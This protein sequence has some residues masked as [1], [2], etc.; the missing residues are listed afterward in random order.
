MGMSIIFLT[1]IVVTLCWTKRAHA[2]TDPYLWLEEIDSE[3]ALDWA[4]SHN[5]TTLDVLQK[6]ADF[7]AIYDKNL[8]IYNSDQ[9]IPAPSIRGDYIYNFWK[10]E[11]NERG[12]WRRTPLEEYRKSDPTWETLLSIDELS[13][14]ESVKWVYKGVSHFYPDFKRCMVSLSRGGGDAVEIREFD[15][16]TKQFVKDGFFVPHAKGSVSWKDINTLHV[17]TDFGA[18]TTTQS[19][20]P[21]LTKVW[22]RGTPLR[23]AETLFEGE[24]DDVSV[25]SDVTYTPERQYTLIR[26]SITFYKGHYHVIENDTQIK[27]DIPEDAQLNGFFKNQMLIRLRSDW[28]VA[29]KPY[30]QGSLIGIDYDRFLNGDR[31]F[32]VIV[33]PDER[34]SISSV[35]S[36]KNLLLVN[37]LTNVRSR[38]DQYRFEENTWHKEKVN[39]PDLGTISIGSTDEFSDRY[40]FY[41][42][43]F[44]VPSTLYLASEEGPIEKLKS[45]PEFFDSSKFE[46]QQFEATSK[47]GT[48]IPYFLVSNTN[49]EHTGKNPTLLSGYGGFEISRQPDYASTVGHAWL[50]RG[51]VYALANIR[52]GGEFGPQWHQAALQKNRQRAYDDFIAVAEDLIDRNITSPQHLGIQGGSNGGL[53]VGAVFTQR[54]DLLNA[55]VCSVPLLDMQRYH[56]LLAGASWMGEYGNPDKPE[57]WAFIQKYSPYHNLHAGQ[58]Y[59]KVFFTTSTR[60]D[61]VHPAHARKMVAKMEAN[62]HECYYYENIEGGHAGSTTNQQTAFRDALIYAYLL[63]QLR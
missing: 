20:Y 2:E 52:G 12:L 4:R 62:G 44:L 21:R 56:K 60:D 18:G 7:Q 54:P 9:R 3:K 27:L 25:W 59:P 14:V 48:Q 58:N 6:Q 38:L 1:I 31:A 57:D 46:V 28:S 19:G 8:E 15:L 42:S 33:V 13:E 37:M 49:L 11:K 53:L 55:V 29:N 35:A 36:T 47:D 26:R 51:G 5:K 22:K 23:E 50:E 45:L 16:A 41:F 43:N 24:E 17:S 40:F 34:S 63:Q 10:D 30:L 39:A 61:R 32:D